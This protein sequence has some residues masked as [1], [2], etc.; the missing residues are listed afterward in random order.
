MKPRSENILYYNAIANEYNE[1]VDKDADRMVREKVAN[2]FCSIV[3]AS[4]V[5]DFGGGTG[6]DLEWLT[7]NNHTVFFCEPSA[8]MRERAMRSHKDLQHN[9]VIFLDDSAT[10]F[11]RWHVQPPFPVKVDAVLSNF[12]VLNCIPDMEL[13]FRNLAVVVK[14]GGNIIALVLTKNIKEIWKGHFR[15]ILKSFINRE[16]ASILVRYKENQQTVY[17]YSIKE[18]IKA[19]RKYFNFYSSEL[20]P[21]SGFTLIHLKRK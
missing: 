4:V 3:K 2:K 16:P 9:N 21:A 14:P 19:S 1:M 10:D 18:I 15:S 20:L 8:G 7:G 6:L 17:I 13:L 11:R 12:A 5:L